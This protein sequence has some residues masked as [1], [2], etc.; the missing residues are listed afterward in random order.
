MANWP[1]MA[2][3]SNRSTKQPHAVIIHGLKHARTACTAARAAG[4]PVELHSAPNAVASL[5]P[6]WFQKILEEIGAEFPDLRIE[7]ILD[8][9]TSAGSA[10]AA[11]RQGLRRIR[12][13]GNRK[14]TEKIRDIARQQ[15]AFVDT[16]WPRALDLGREADPA[17]AC[18]RW[19]GDRDGAGG[20]KTS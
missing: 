2:K 9:G 7:G 16:R 18:R 19:F 5:G 20:D 12:F 1:P 8:C 3:Q 11:L 15:A 10:L 14:A 4:M 17:T 6:H 13:S